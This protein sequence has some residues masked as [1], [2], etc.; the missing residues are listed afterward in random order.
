MKKKYIISG[1]G[2]CHTMEQDQMLNGLE[3]S[4]VNFKYGSIEFTGTDEQL[5]LFL[6]PLYEND[7]NFKVIGV[8]EY[9]EEEEQYY[10]NLLT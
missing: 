1:K 5:T 3:Y 4:D 6:E 8:H 2:Y 7:T 10:K 9:N